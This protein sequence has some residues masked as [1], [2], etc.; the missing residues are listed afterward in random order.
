MFSVKAHYIITYPVASYPCHQATACLRGT[1][2]V[3]FNDVSEFRLYNTYN[4]TEIVCKTVPITFLI[5][6]GNIA[7]SDDQNYATFIS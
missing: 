5:K 1:S 6:N 2:N 3:L 4:G 7:L